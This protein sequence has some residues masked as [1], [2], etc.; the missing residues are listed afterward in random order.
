MII[1]RGLLDRTLIVRGYTNGYGVLLPPSCG[2]REVV[3]RDSSVR[4]LL[5]FTTGVYNGLYA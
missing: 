5:T 4:R 2:Y 3:L 1:T